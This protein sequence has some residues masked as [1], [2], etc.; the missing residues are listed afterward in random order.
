M[1]IIFV[2]VLLSAQVKE[3]SSFCVWNFFFRDYLCEKNIFIV[4]KYGYFLNLFYPSYIFHLLSKNDGVSTVLHSVTI[5]ITVL[6]HTS[7]YNTVVGGGLFQTF[8]GLGVF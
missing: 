3:F 8:M 2:P 5:L 4:K 1:K 7:L 6:H